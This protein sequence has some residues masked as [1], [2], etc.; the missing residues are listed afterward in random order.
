MARRTTPVQP[1]D[2]NQDAQK[3]LFWRDEETTAKRL[4]ETARDRI[5]SL[6]TMRNAAGKFI[7]GRED[8]NGHRH[9]DLDNPVT[10]ND[11]EYTSIVAQRKT[12][13]SLDQDAVEQLLRE[14]GGDKLYDLVF[15]REVIRVFDQET[16]YV[17]LQKGVISEDELDSVTTESESW[18]L[19]AVKA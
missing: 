16:L 8:E 11:I 9:Y 12:S 1:T 15:K 17:L 7:Y 2:L 18:A 10:V 4:K 14:K 5:K 6:L 3:F 19:T 13:S